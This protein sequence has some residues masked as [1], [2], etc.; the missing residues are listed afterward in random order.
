MPRSE[1]A[2]DASSSKTSDGPAYLIGVPMRV[3]ISQVIHQS[4]LAWPGGSTTFSPICTRRSV[5]V[6]VPAFSKNDVA[7]RIT[8]ANSAVSVRKMSWTTRKSSAA[9]AFLT[10]LMFGS[11]RNGFSPI[12]YMP[13]TRFP[14]A[15]VMISTTVSPGSGS[16]G[17][18]I[19]HAAW[20]RARTAGSPTGW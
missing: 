2:S 18:D 10:L 5:F 9:S 8:S 13:R 14:S 20:K 4:G 15:A 17:S 12:M 1:G 11:D 3:A 7:G 19:P 6:Y 16:S